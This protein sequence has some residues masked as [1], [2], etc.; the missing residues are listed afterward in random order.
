MY[1]KEVLKRFS[2][3]NSK[4]ELVPFRY[5][6]HLSKKMCPSTPEKI[7]CMSKIPYASV[8]GSLMY[9]MLCTRPDIAHAVSV[10]SRYQSNPDE[11]HQTFVKCIL[12]Y[13]KR[14]KDMLLV[15]S[16]GEL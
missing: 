16:N 9:A 10:T 5:D 12:K 6:I 8:I 3:E 4:R 1:I 11:E 13:L 15:I 7:E 2:I 14:T